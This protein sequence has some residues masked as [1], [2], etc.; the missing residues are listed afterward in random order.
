MWSINPFL[1]CTLYALYTLPSDSR[2]R[3][4]RHPAGRD[5]GQ[6]NQHEGALGHSRMRQREQWAVDAPVAVQQQIQIKGARGIAI[7]ALPSG[8][9]FELL[10]GTQQ[11]RGTE[12][13]ED[14]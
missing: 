14:S 4:G 1:A 2:Q 13:G 10:H 11:I 3:L 5:L 12:A 6:R 8:S 7:G 9:Q